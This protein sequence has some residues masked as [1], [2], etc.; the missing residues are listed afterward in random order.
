MSRICAVSL[1][2]VLLVPAKAAA[3]PFGEVAPFTLERGCVKATGMPGELM[4]E[5]ETGVRFMRAARAGLTPGEDVRGD[6]RCES[7]V[8]RPS[9]AGLLADTTTD[10]DVVATLREPGGAWGPT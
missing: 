3:S 5:T 8:A 10:D 7:V 2:L 4:T 1:F 6:F 9:G